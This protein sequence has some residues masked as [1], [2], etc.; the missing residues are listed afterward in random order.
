[1]TINLDAQ[2]AYLGSAVLARKISNTQLSWDIETK[3]IIN[4]VYPSSSSSSAVWHKCALALLQRSRDII[5]SKL[6]KSL[7]IMSCN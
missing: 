3:E 4:T 5:Y 2:P 1:V 7:R 6:N